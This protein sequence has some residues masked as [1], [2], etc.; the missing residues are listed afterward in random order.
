MRVI[1]AL[2]RAIRSRCALTLHAA[3]AAAAGIP[4]LRVI[5]AALMCRSRCSINLRSASAAAAQRSNT[6]CSLRVRSALCAALR[7][8]QQV[9]QLRIAR[10]HCMCSNSAMCRALQQWRLRSEPLLLLLSSTLRLL[11]HSALAVLRSAVKPQQ[12]LLRCSWSSPTPRQWR[13]HALCCAHATA[14]A[15]AALVVF[16]LRCARWCGLRCAGVPSRTCDDRCA[17]PVPRCSA[18]SP[19]HGSYAL[20]RCA[21]RSSQPVSTLRR[22]VAASCRQAALSRCVYCSALNALLQ[23][24][25]ARSVNALQ[26]SGKYALV[27]LLLQRECAAAALRM[28][29]AAALSLLRVFTCSSAPASLAVKP[30]PAVG[31]RCSVNLLP[32]LSVAAAHCSRCWIYALCCAASPA[33]A[34]SSRCSCALLAALHARCLHASVNHAAPVAHAALRCDTLRRVAPALLACAAHVIRCTAGVSPACGQPTLTLCSLLTHVLT[35]LR[36]KSFALHRQH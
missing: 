6:R 12:L 15:H 2:L 19:T 32:L 5:A 10:L 4:Q 14:V 8:M 3:P 7:C 33:A 30:A 26:I 16:P 29:Y 23:A 17:A 18:C 36:C 20:L 11:T 13:S 25:A 9:N 35:L 24:V 27:N 34:A 21:A 28:R 31:S 1:C 22:M